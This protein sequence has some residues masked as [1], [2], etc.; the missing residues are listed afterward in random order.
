MEKKDI[1]K[2]VMTKLALSSPEQYKI[3]ARLSDKELLNALRQVIIAE[4]D[5]INL[6]EALKGATSNEKFIKV[7]DH[8]IKEEKEHV[9]EAQ[10]LLH[11][12]D[13]EQAELYLED[14]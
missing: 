13:P 7:I 4:F 14:H 5:A 12:L 11:E 6:Y 1:K 8:L 10:A 3:P 2:R 9:V